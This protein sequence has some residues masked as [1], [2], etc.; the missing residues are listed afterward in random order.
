M[1]TKTSSQLCWSEP[2][3]RE[4]KHLQELPASPD[5]AEQHHWKNH[6]LHDGLN[7]ISTVNQVLTYS[8]S[9]KRTEEAGDK[10]SST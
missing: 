7:Y 1:Y 3:R 6:D 2:F 10:C 5:V 8:R 9:D 4:V